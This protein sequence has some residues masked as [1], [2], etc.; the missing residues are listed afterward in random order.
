MAGGV[1]G[2]RGG[3]GG[4]LRLLRE[5][6]EAVEY[7]L[8]AL[9]LRLDDL[10]TER[11]SWRDLLVIARQSPPGSALNR[12]LDPG[13]RATLDTHLLRRIEHAGRVSVWQNAGGRGP[14]PEPLTLPWEQRERAW[15][16][17]VLEWDEAADALGGD[18]R[19]RE[20]MRRALASM[21]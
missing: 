20:A 5:H 12:A 15:D 13:W 7:D 6:G 18:E 10:G 9:G 1:R 19:M 3:I 21:T 2:G 16:H 4:L 8:I 17:D 14:A 11:L